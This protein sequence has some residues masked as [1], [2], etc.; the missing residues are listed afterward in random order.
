MF[1][2]SAPRVRLK[3]HPRQ[4]IAEPWPAVPNSLDKVRT[5]R[6]A[7]RTMIRYSH[8]AAMALPGIALARIAF[9]CP[10]TE[11]RAT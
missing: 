7:E 3:G 10:L 2:V 1:R 8:M 6:H 4:E 9:T 5:R 11:E